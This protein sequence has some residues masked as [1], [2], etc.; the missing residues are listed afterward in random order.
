MHSRIP[1]SVAVG[2]VAI[3]LGQIAAG[4]GTAHPVP[5]TGAAT[6]N[7]AASANESATGAIAAVQTDSLAKS[8]NLTADSKSLPLWSEP[9]PSAVADLTRVVRKAA[10]SVFLVGKSDVG[11]G[12][13]FLISKKNRLLATNAHVADIF[14]KGSGDMLAY[15]NGT[16]N[17]F[18][19][20]KAYYH[21][22]VMRMS[23]GV[24][25]RTANPSSGNVFPRSPD[26]AVLQLADDGHELPDELPL[27]TRDEMYD[28]FAQSVCMLGFPGH[29]T[30]NLPRTG[31]T[32][33]ATFR[34]GVISR[35]ADFSN[36][37]GS[38]PARQQYLQHS[39]A[40]W[41]G[42][43]GSP[44][45]LPNGHV[46]GLNNSGA[47]YN[48][49]GLST[50]IAFGIRADCLWELL[51]AD[52]LLDKVELAPEAA[53]VDID[54]FSQPDPQMERLQ[55]VNQL[56]AEAR[57]DS[58]YLRDQAAIAKCNEAAQQLPEYAAIYSLRGAVYMEYAA[59]SFKPSDPQTRKYNQLAL[60]DEN[61][62]L[63]LDPTNTSCYLNVGMA[64]T[65]LA[66]LNAPNSKRKSVPASM[67][68]ADRIIGNPSVSPREKA[69][70][71]R[72]RA[73]AMGLTPD[74]W[75]YLKKADALMPHNARV[76]WT[77]NIY[78]AN[79]NKPQEAARHKQLSLTLQEA[80][81]KSQTAWKLATSKDDAE[82]DGKRAFALASEACVST[83]NE[84]Y[85]ALNALAA[86]Y[87][88]SGDFP[89]A[90]EYEKKALAVAPEHKRA[91]YTQCLASYQ[92]HKPWRDP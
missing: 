36:D 12:T 49:N 74:S 59:H 90:V 58:R 92:E 72:L 9:A 56:L 53:L 27:A 79:N 19:V 48:V 47:T 43:S 70:A 8:L 20:V 25:L 69:D 68:L 15:Q 14:N 23:S 3:V 87:A 2:I 7:E 45:I 66:N 88:E 84:V 55:K 57:D 18:K 41:Y 52:Q 54:R 35:V 21:P 38:M 40:N 1:A 71:Y 5:Q 16:A 62:A 61:L 76:H 81:A 44:I 26:V 73:D 78:Y 83:D 42:F 80:L 34:E 89:H 46:A 22:G 6:I 51:K 17:V 75:E 77:M 31:Q 32:A 30:S 28:I 64:N 33:G 13:A 11:T 24:I 37:T 60:E 82:R 39:M 65:N 10:P 67:E 50:N 86:A 91:P 63:Q 85:Y 4:Q 29:D